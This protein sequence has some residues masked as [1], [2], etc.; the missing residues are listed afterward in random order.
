MDP[1]LALGAV[2]TLVAGTSLLGLVLKRR[3]GRATAAKGERAD[4]A[5]LD[6]DALPAR[7]T[8]LQF[9]SEFCARCPGTARA[10]GEIA[11]TD[12]DLAHV[13]LDVATHLELA[14]RFHVTQTPTVVV[15]DGDGN[16]LQRFAGAPMRADVTAALPPSIEHPRTPCVTT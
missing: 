9:S 1:L 8:L 5:E 3:E 4:A 11:A 10:L 14:S 12:G 13:E 6:L 7:A 16:A 15:L 2:A